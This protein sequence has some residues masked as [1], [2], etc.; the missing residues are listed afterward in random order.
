MKKPSISHCVSGMA[1][2]DLYFHKE[3]KL[4]WYRWTQL[5]NDDEPTYR[6]IEDVFVV[7]FN[8]DA[9]YMAVYRTTSN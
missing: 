8:G 1:L 2:V 3:R 5:A 6:F 4:G 7:R 9:E